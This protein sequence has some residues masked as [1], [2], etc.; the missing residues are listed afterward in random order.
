[1]NAQRTSLAEDL[2]TPVEAPAEPVS[3]RAFEPWASYPWFHFLY[4]TVVFVLVATGL[5]IQYPDWRARLI[6]GYG[7][8]VAWWHEWAGVAMLV[9]PLLAFALGPAEAWETIQLRSWRLEKLAIHAI[10]LWF[11]IVSGA[12]FVVTGFLL[13]FQRGLPDPVIDW[14]Y[15]LH[16]V[17]SYALYVMIPLH[18]LASLGRTVRNLRA[19]L[20]RVRLLVTGGQRTEKVR[21]SREGLTCW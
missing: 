14:S 17:F 4:A 19:R 20:V 3:S 9:V 15:T 2:E 1:M 16:D 7:Q 6:G 21:T 18:V 8:T 13:W 10:N 5:L 12:V 11:T